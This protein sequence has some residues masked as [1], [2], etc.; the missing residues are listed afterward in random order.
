[1]KH[2]PLLVSIVVTRSRSPNSSTPRVGDVL[3]MGAY[4]SIHS[5]DGAAFET[6]LCQ[7]SPFYHHPSAAAS[8]APSPR[9]PTLLGLNLLNLLLS[10][11]LPEYHTHLARLD[12]ALPA[13]AFVIHLEQCLQEGTFHRLVAAR[14][15]LPV[16][17]YAWFLDSLIERVRDDLAA[18]LER[19][20][21]SRLKA[22]QVGAL[23]LLEPSAMGRVLEFAQRR[24]WSIHGDEIILPGEV[25]SASDQ[26]S[27][28]P[29]Q[30][31][32]RALTYA[33]ALEQIV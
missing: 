15:Q 8:V 12:P 16:P 27:T 26:A 21:S 18:S 17:E 14:A 28:L 2:L 1:M 9:A 32:G 4:W 22:A 23:L 3:E 19:S 10:N 11:R 29:K 6:Y 13:V 24:G 7:L 30:T 33:S 20:F 31:I 5:Q 25:A